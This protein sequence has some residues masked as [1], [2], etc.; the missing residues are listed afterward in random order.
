MA[1][2]D[3][4]VNLDDLKAAYDS[5]KAAIA[6]T[7]IKIND[8]AL[9]QINGS[10]VSVPQVEIGT[11]VTA[12]T[13]SYTLNKAPDTLTLKVGSA[14]ASSILPTPAVESSSYQKTGLSLTGNTALKL[15]AG[16]SGSDAQAAASDEKTV[17]LQFLPKVYWG[18]AAAPEAVNSAFILG[19]SGNALATG[20]AREFTVNAGSG[21]YIWYASPVSYGACEFY[22][23]GFLG[24]FGAA[25]TISLTNASGYTQNYYVYRSTNANLGSTT[26]VVQ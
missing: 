16:D 7:P 6:Y 17:T 11:T 2:G 14:A 13:I 10:N 25:Q 24:G 22:V 9:T 4:L 15:T 20:K 26:V 21:K 8:F 1:T 3:K 12:A 19:L 5:L 18:A 23:G